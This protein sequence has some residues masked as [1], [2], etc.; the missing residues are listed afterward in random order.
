[1]FLYMVSVLFSAFEST[2]IQ[3]GKNKQSSVNTIINAP[4]SCAI[5]ISTAFLL[6][7]IKTN[8]FVVA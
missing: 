6:L 4:T 7:S 2:L 5:R 3:L 1:M 8:A